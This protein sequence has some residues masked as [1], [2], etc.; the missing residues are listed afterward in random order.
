MRSIIVLA[1]LTLSLTAC[2]SREEWGAALIGV[3]DRM[4]GKSS[5]ACTTHRQGP[6]VYTHCY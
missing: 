4:E 6:Y 2:Y 5:V 1:I 3:A